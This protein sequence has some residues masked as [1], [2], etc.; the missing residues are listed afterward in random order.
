ML[1]VCLGV[2]DCVDCVVGV[3]GQDFH[4]ICVV[5]AVYYSGVQ[6]SLPIVNLILINGNLLIRPIFSIKRRKDNLII[7]NRGGKELIITS[8]ERIEYKLLNLLPI[9]M[10]KKY[11]FILIILKQPIPMTKDP[12]TFAPFNLIQHPGNLVILLLVFSHDPNIF[13]RIL[14]FDLFDGLL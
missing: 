11:S 1:L 9:L 5:C 8:P 10:S 2:E 6:D 4:Q 12:H 14:T 13:G 3:V 7:L